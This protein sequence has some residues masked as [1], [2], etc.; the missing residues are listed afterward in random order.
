MWK[1]QE[2]H[3]I[4][5]WSAVARMQS[6]EALSVVHSRSQTWYALSSSLSGYDQ[7]DFVV[8]GHTDQGLSSIAMGDVDGLPAY[9]QGVHRVVS[10]IP[11]AVAN[12][13]AVVHTVS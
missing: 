5:Y 10:A 2:V 4:C 9:D 3:E 6:F 8:D 12:T 7:V 11:V 1:R 13:A